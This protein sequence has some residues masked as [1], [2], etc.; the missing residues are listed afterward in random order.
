M[1]KTLLAAAAFAV[2]S[3]PAYAAAPNLVPDFNTA[4]GI[5]T[6]KNAGDAPSN[7]GF[8]TIK[9]Q[10]TV[11]PVVG[12]GGGCP[13]IPAK[14]TP[15]YTNPAFPNSVTVNVPALRP[16]ATFTHTLAFYGSLV[17]VAGS[18]YQFTVTADA[19]NSSAESNE[20]D[21][22]IIRTRP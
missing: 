6:V 5:V 11:P 4:R 7:P 16:G 19:S 20:G 12:G 21:N 10:R 2:L 9:C 18:T 15:N 17:F 14:F 1:K 8:V 13:E 22:V 3:M